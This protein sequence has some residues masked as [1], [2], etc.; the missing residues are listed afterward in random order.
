M[1]IAQVSPLFESVPPR[2]YGGTERIVF[3][4][5]EELIQNG[6]EVT[7]Y[8]S[9]DSLSRAKLRA[10]CRESLRQAGCR[11][12][13][14]PHAAM[15]EMLRQEADHYDLIHFHTEVMH[16]NITRVLG[17]VPTITTMHGRLDCSGYERLF[18]E[19]RD[20]PLVSISRHQKSAAPFMNWVGTVYHGLNP[21][22]LKFRPRRGEYLAFLGRIS[23]EKRVDRAIEIA[24]R[25]GWKLKVAAKLD[26]QLDGAYVE[27]VMPLLNEPHVEFVGEISDQEKLE[28]LGNA[29][30]LLFPIDWPEPFGLV[31]IESLA[32]GT[33]V[34]AFGCGSVPEVIRDGLTGFVVNSIEDACEAVRNVDRIERHACRAE[35]ES[36]FSAERMTRDYLRIYDHVSKGNALAGGI[37]P[38]EC[39][40]S[41]L[42][43]G[44]IRGGLN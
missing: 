27:E 5:T 6:H 30:G 10:P 28:F 15:F 8:A 26:W 24:R 23:R 11:E 29:A 40:S 16:F 1:R 37:A 32:V 12:D 19:Y 43:F 44:E 4:L 38:A 21:D 34:I 2:L 3:N 35:F 41:H 7:L 36:R 39:D 22:L 25:T 18:A 33:P 20:L 13:F 31:M 42:F 17:G 14:A 9:G